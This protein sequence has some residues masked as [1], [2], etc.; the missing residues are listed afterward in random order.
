V[1]DEWRFASH[2]AQHSQQM[3]SIHVLQTPGATPMI[4]PAL[5]VEEAVDMLIKVGVDCQSPLVI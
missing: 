2:N 4:Y 3:P 5:V 1:A